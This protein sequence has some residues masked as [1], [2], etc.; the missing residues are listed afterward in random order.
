MEKNLEEQN[1]SIEDFS[2]RVEIS[3]IHAIKH[4]A[5]LNCG[6]TFLYER[7]V[8]HELE[9]GTLVRL[10]PADFKVYHDFTFIWRK[11][12]V[13]WEEYEEFFHIPELQCK[14]YG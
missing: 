13:F 9:E 2:N 14:L 6:I 3:N 10:K 5:E 11:G 12:S 4:L 7:A 1:F 8:K